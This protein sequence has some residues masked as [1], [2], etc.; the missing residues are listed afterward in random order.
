MSI[1]KKKEKKRWQTY[2][3]PPVNPIVVRE[4]VSWIKV[5]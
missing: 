5:V 2:I 4:V 3:K 1:T